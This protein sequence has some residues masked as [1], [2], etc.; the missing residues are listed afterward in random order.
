LDKVGFVTQIMAV[1]AR[2]HLRDP[3]VRY[4][5]ARHVRIDSQPP[6]QGQIDGD[7]Y[8]QTPFEIAIV[9]QALTLFV[10]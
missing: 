6:I 3:R 5:R 1:L 2:R 10:P 8:G 9:P 4:Y 7:T